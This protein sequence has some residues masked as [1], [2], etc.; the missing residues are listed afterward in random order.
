MNATEIDPPIYGRVKAGVLDALGYAPH[1]RDQLRE[2]LTAGGIYGCAV[3]LTPVLGA[4]ILR[5]EIA[6]GEDAMYRLAPERERSALDAPTE[7]RP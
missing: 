6:L 4:M 7:D 5:K 3:V 2:Y 1:T